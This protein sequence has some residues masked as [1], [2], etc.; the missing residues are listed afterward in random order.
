M[1]YR[2]IRESETVATGD[3]WLNALNTSPRDIKF[4]VG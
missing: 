1:S 2:S 4:Y 3:S